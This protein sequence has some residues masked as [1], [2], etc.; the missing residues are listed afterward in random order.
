MHKLKA[1]AIDDICE[2]E[3][4]VFDEKKPNKALKQIQS[5]KEIM[6]NYFK[7]QHFLK[8]GANYDFEMLNGV[9]LY[10]ESKIAYENKKITE[11]MIIADSSIIQFK[12]TYTNF[13][14]LGLIEEQNSVPYQ[15]LGIDSKLWLAKALKFRSR[16]EQET[17]GKKISNY[18]NQAEILFNDIINNSGEVGESSQNEALYH[19]CSSKIKNWDGDVKK[20]ISAYVMLDLNYKKVNSKDPFYNKIQKLYDKII[21]NSINVSLIEDLLNTQKINDRL[22]Q[23]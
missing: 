17:T 3:E 15:F 10:I 7:N 12:K 5:A 13:K 23:D 14:E 1:K 16:L 18:L 4:I 2:A 22:N 20:Y 6:N 8:T 21:D 9:L 11:S 19:L